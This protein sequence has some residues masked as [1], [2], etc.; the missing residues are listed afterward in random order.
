M[1]VVSEKFEENGIGW[2]Y[3]NI[4]IMFAW[5][6]CILFFPHLKFFGMTKLTL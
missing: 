4:A 3:I 2:K 1:S 6:L 5:A